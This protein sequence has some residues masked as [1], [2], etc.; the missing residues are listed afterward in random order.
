MVDRNS[1]TLI[2]VLKEFVYNMC[3][4]QGK[5]PFDIFFAC[6]TC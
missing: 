1:L 6:K 2:E 3:V 4:W 5:R